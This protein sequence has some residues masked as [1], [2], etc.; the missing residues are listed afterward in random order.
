ME[1]DK[2]ALKAAVDK[3]DALR[4]ADYTPETWSVF[5]QALA[6][7]K[8]V[9]MADDATQE[10]V[11]AAAQTL[12]DAV[13]GL[14]PAETTDPD[15]P[16]DPDEP[17]DTVDTSKLAATIAKGQAIDR[18]AYTAESLKA[19]DQALSDAQQVMSDKDATQEEVDAAIQAIEDALNGLQK[20][21]TTGGQTKPG[22]QTTKPGG[23][24]SATGAAVIGVTA[25]TLLALAGAVAIAARRYM[26]GK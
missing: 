26:T 4:E 5:S 18:N 23:N 22:D 21:P 3:A 14:K 2:S 11:D 19:L 6:D 10:Q 7:A 8:A 24:L 16:D 25:V 15:D 9:L 13:L 17:G 1:A 20:A 12:Q